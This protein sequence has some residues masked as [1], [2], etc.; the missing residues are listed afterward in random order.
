MQFIMQVNFIIKKNISWNNADSIYSVFRHIVIDISQIMYS[1][2]L[3]LDYLM[4]QHAADL[5][6]GFC[7][8]LMHL[9]VFND[10]RKEPEVLFGLRCAMLRKDLSIV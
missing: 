3:V 4:G 10:D 7:R 8:Y 5:Y 2:L 6:P 9:T 1:K